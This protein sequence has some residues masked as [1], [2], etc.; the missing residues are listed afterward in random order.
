MG[1]LFTTSTTYEAQA[2]PKGLGKVCPLEGKANFSQGTGEIVIDKEYSINLQEQNICQMLIR[3]IWFSGAGY[4]DLNEAH[5]IE[6]EVIHCAAHS[7][8]L[9][10]KSEPNGAVK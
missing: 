1:R 2:P 7:F 10:L 6:V 5:G 8:L 4:G 9:T 3:R